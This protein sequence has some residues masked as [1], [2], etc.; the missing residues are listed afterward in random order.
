MDY[1]T[2]PRFNYAE[3]LEYAKSMGLPV[4]FPL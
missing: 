2:Q 3:I 1:E 4:D